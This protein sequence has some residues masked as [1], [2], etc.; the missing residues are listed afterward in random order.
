VEDGHTGLL[1]PPGDAEALADALRTIAGGGIDLST[2][3]KAAMVEGQRSLDINTIGRHYDRILSQ[4]S[5]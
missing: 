3:G 5:R 2:M 1:V 4:V